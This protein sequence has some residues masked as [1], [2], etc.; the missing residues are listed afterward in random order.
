MD[1]AADGELWRRAVEG[2]P[3]AFGVLFDRHGERVRAYCARRTG[4]LDAADDLVS[5]VFLEAW[6]RRADVQLLGD[7]ALPWLYG[8]ANHT[9]QRRFR[10]TLRHQRA[11]SRVRP[12]DDVPDHAD[13]VAARLDDQR[14]LAQLH[15]AL[16][17]LRRTD[18]EV[19]V[20]CLWQGLDYEATAL[21]LDLP[22]GTVRSRLSRAR[23]RLR[24]ELARSHGPA[25]DRLAPLIPV[26]LS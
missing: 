17:G 9:V 13:D 25:T 26:E 1:E 2:E 8:I 11:L 19:L 7:S 12:G 6:R 20:L 10:T 21:A 4:S 22:V 14:H 18:Q 23:V 5:V 15:T 16:R 3:E 24:E